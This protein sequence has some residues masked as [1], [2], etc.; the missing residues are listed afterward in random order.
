MSSKLE[1]FVNEFPW[2]ENES[3]PW[4][5]FDKALNESKVAVVSTGGLYVYCDKPFQIEDRQDVDESFRE[6]PLEIESEQIEIAHEHYEKRYVNKDI[7]TVFPV[8][9]LK[10]LEAEGFIGELSNYNFSITGYIPEP[11]ELFATGKEIA[12]KLSE[13]EIDAVLI[14]PV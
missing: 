13:L 8:E 12:G 9:R 7:N 5:V 3:S 2:V 4:A 10:E 14:V 6:I 11:D 1:K